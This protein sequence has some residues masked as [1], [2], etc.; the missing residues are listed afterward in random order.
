MTY[1]IVILPQISLVISSD[2]E[3]RFSDGCYFFMHFFQRNSH[4]KSDAGLPFLKRQWKLTKHTWG[5][6]WIVISVIAFWAANIIF[7]VEYNRL[8]LY[9]LIY[10]GLCMYVHIHLLYVSMYRPYFGKREQPTLYQFCRRIKKLGLFYIS[11]L[12]WQT[13]I[14]HLSYYSS[15][16]FCHPLHNIQEDQLNDPLNINHCSSTWQLD[17]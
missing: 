3:I 17:P 6:F 11:Q 15:R 14:P 10:I 2:Q 13:D 4:V 12:L 9:T 5:K 7:E 16:W 1:L 8:S